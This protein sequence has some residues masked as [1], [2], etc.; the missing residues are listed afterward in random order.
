MYLVSYKSATRPTDLPEGATVE[1]IPREF[2]LTLTTERYREFTITKQWDGGWGAHLAI[3]RTAAS[4]DVFGRGELSSSLSPDSTREL[5]HALL[6]AIGDPL[7]GNEVADEVSDADATVVLDDDGD[8]WIRASNGKF[9]CS[10][11]SETPR[12]PSR[13]GTSTLEEIR[14]DYP[15]LKV[16]R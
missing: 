12:D 13:R 3:A 1:R 8:Y 14:R 10:Y 9:Y 4:A 11:S 7:P 16:V 15:G 2:P 6:E 5:A